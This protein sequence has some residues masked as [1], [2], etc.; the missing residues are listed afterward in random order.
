MYRCTLH[1]WV[2]LQVPSWN[3]AA[4]INFNRYEPILMMSELYHM[5][6]IL[7][8]FT[9]AAWRRKPVFY[10][11]S[12]TNKTKKST[13]KVKLFLKKP[14]CV[15]VINAKVQKTSLS[16]NPTIYTL[17]QRRGQEYNTCALLL[18]L[19]LPSTLPSRSK[20]GAIFSFSWEGFFFLILIQIFSF[21]F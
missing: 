1:S 13:K 14:S 5:G 16:Q 11:S 2:K 12:Q 20:K 18:R 9:A 21:T 19:T 17:L 3:S 4:T 6:Q 10:F 7:V 8:H 15:A